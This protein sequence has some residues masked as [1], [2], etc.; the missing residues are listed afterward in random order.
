MDIDV[1]IGAQNMGNNEEIFPSEE[2][3]D[4][5]KENVPDEQPEQPEQPENPEQPEQSEQPEQKRRNRRKIRIMF[6]EETE[7]TNEQILEMRQ[8]VKDNLEDAEIA[9]RE[10]VVNLPN[11]NTFLL[12]FNFI[13]QYFIIL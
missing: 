5:N 7:L 2:Q 11:Y 4:A 8:S 12:M 6:D 1:D 3:D 9:A 10:K 13:F